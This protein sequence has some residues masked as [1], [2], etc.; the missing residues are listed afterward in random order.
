MMTTVL[1]IL[2]ALVIFAI[3]KANIYSISIASNK[4]LPGFPTKKRDSDLA[5][6]LRKRTNAIGIT[7]K[8]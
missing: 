1:I 2:T 5:T 7:K 3:I 6:A 8:Y 4:I